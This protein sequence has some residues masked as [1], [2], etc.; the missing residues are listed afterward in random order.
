[1][2]V[3]V[4]SVMLPAE[5]KIMSAADESVDETD[6]HIPLW[7]GNSSSQTSHRAMK[8]HRLENYERRRLIAWFCHFTFP[9]LLFGPSSSSPAFKAFSIAPHTRT[10]RH[11]SRQVDEYDFHK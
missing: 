8:T 9:V 3:V 4:D 2:T 6:H 10:H 5:D 1:M 11:A 7:I